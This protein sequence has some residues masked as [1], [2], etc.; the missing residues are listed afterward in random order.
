MWSLAARMNPGPWRGN[1]W[2]PQ[3]SGV[4]SAID[5]ELH[6]VGIK[7]LGMEELDLLYVLFCN[8]W[9]SGASVM[10]RRGFPAQL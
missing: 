8:L 9:P 5:L 7:R 6:C 3:L 4:E 2:T 10:R 1:L